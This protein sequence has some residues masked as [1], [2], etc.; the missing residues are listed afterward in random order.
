METRQQSERT[1]KNRHWTKDLKCTT[2]VRMAFIGKRLLGIRNTENGCPVG[3]EILN[4]K[5]KY[6]SPQLLEPSI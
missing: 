4:A 2:E 5:S 1:F 6:S 3:T